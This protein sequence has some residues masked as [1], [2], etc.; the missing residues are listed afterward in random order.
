MNLVVPQTPSG[1]KFRACVEENT[2]SQ[3]SHNFK[4]KVFKNMSL[5]PRIIKHAGK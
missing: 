5:Q 2:L 4:E 3:V 1:G